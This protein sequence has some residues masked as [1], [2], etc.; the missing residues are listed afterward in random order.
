MIACAAACTP[1]RSPVVE[2]QAPVATS[3][4]P[5][6]SATGLPAA[7]LLPG[8]CL[9]IPEKAFRIDRVAMQASPPDPSFPYEARSAV[10]VSTDRSLD[11]DGDGQ[12]DALV[13]E[14]APG[15]C[16][17][18]MHAAVY[19]ARGACG[20]RVGVVVGSVRPTAGSQPGALPDLTTTVESGYQDDP[21]VPAQ[22]RTVTRT[23]RFDGTAYR[24]AGRKTEDAICHHCGTVRCTA[25]PM[26]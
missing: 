24:E 2:V 19:V 15:D 5:S 18:D 26:P 10:G 6:S 22:R 13:P 20:H 11:I 9:P 16:N 25:S 23:Y 8:P 21:R 4:A 14:P 17:N 7:N 1:E 12:R 3:G